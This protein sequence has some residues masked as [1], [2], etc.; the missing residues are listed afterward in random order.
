[1][2]SAVN[3]FASAVNLVAML[4]LAVIV[5]KS[6]TLNLTIVNLAVIVNVSATL[7]LAV[8]VNL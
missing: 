7:N 5:N 2:V 1:M 6:A 8:V 4:N 3:Y